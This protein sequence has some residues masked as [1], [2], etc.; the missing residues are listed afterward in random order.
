MLK[1][2]ENLKK[3]L[4]N[5]INDLNIKD[6][7][8]GGINKVKFMHD[9]QILFENATVEDKYALIL[10][11]IAKFKIINEL[12]G[13]E[14]ANIIL[15]DIYDIIKKNLFGNDLLTRSSAA[16]YFFVVKYT[17]EED[18]K[19]LV[20]KIKKDIDAYNSEKMLVYKKSVKNSVI[21]TKL[22][23]QFGI[24]MVNDFSVPIYMMCDR[25]SLAKRTI[26]GDV[27]K[28]IS[29]YDDNLRQ[30]LLNEKTIEDEM[31]GALESN[32]F[33]MYLQPKYNMRTLEIIGSEALVRWIHPIR[34]FIPPCDFIPLFE[35]NG[36]ILNLDRYI[37]EQAC[38][39]IRRW[40]DEGKKPI[41]ISVNVSRVHLS[42]EL[43]IKDL[44]D[45]V[46]MYNIPTSLLELEL[47]ESAGYEDFPQFLKIVKELKKCGF[48]IA[49]DDFGSGYS[50]LN[51]LRQIPCDILKLDR[52]FINDTTYNE[53]GK[54]VVQSILTM[55]KNLDLKTVSEGIE[56][57]EQAN[58]L[59]Q[60]GCDIAQGFLYAKPM[61][62][63][64]FENLA[65]SNNKLE[66]K[67]LKTE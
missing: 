57:V 26:S 35:K 20:N 61:S 17:Q 47:T 59:N 37:W 29:F 9:V 27:N 8:T 56:T 6:N 38:L 45:L 46:K 48:S 58:F 64:D 13:F 1:S 25:V 43:F 39:T 15:K 28:Y 34:G 3:Q 19:C 12:Y 10:M 53:R 44:N 42:N 54:I 30:Q 63:K 36:F 66:I 51:M 33:V 49:M 2:T 24:Y 14:S 55:A 7:I 67:G 22:L 11:D 31:Y 41:P 16:T 40:I 32:Q 23:P 21:Y 50:S 5:K 62:V 60:S 52:G 4:C 18:I 65:F